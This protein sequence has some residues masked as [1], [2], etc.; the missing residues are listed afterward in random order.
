MYAADVTSSP[1]R[2]LVTGASGFLGGHLVR[3]LASRGIAVHAQ[4]RDTA[5]LAFGSGVQICRTPLSDVGAL[6]DA[7]KGCDAIVHAAALSAPWGR[8]QDFVDANVVGTANVI[9]AARAARVRRLV[10]ISSPAVI[11][12]GRDQH[13]LDDSTPYPARLGCEY[14]R[15]KRAAETLVRAAAGDID[16]VTLRPKAIYGAG[17]R[18]LVPR[19]LRAA[20][21]GALP[22][23]GDGTN[24]VDVTHV[25][26]V[27][28]AIE[29]AL[30]SDRG[31]GET[32][33][34][35]GGEHVPLWP[36]IRS[37][38]TGVGLP[39]PS[40][41]LS[42]NAALVVAGALEVVAAI[43]GREP[44][45]TRYSAQILARTQTYDITRAQTL[46]GYTPRVTSG[47]GIAR[48]IDALR[49]ES[50]PS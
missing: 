8:R 29:C 31:V 5:R 1:R 37:L 23:I 10:H 14:A 30:I 47:D 4:G 32:F 11:F 16:T 48:T 21:R 25:D 44:T 2:V 36:M 42:L 34:I 49:R 22:E 50:A 6:T 33:L 3:A 9:T 13:L 46:L 45:L 17:D 38:L 19:L 40:R 27:V 39:V 20:R 18:A 7:A 15:T 43:T 12:D 24:N 35:T 26:D 41:H 28:H